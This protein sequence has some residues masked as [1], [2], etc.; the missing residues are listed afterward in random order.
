M[1]N[2]TVIALLL[3]TLSVAGTAQLASNT[4]IV[5]NVPFDFIA[6]NQ[7]VPAGQCI[8]Q[9]AASS[10]ITIRNQAAHAAML[11]SVTPDRDRKAT[12]KY[13]LVFNEYGTRHF[14]REIRTASG[15]V[16]KLPESKLER[17]MLAQNIVPRHEVLLA[18]VR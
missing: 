15:A 11:T 7:T 12:G 16:Y 2:A 6:R 17:E 18:S 8:V 4:K 10:V 1:K 9:S 3:L 14:L 13:S 5:T